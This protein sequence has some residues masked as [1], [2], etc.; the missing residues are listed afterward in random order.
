[1]IKELKISN[2]KRNFRNMN[3]KYNEQEL[4]VFIAQG[5]LE[6]VRDGDHTSLACI[7]ADKRDKARLLVKDNGI[8]AGVEVAKKI[9]MF[10][11]PTANIEVFIND[12]EEVKHG[13]VAFIVECN[14]QALL[15]AERLA[16]NTMQRM[17]GIATVTRRYV[18]EV[19]GLD[20]KILDTRKTT[21]LFR[22]L[23][24]WAVFIGGGTNYRWGLYD[25]MMIKDNHIDAAGGVTQA[26]QRALDYQEANDKKL[27]ITVE[28]RDLKELG[29]VL[30]IG[31]ITRIML[32]NFSV[33][34]QKEAVKIING[35]F[36]VE[37][38]GGITLET[39][40]D[41]A[42]TGVDFVSIGALTH[43][44]QSLDLSLKII[45]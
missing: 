43:S 29:E 35:R 41:K 3:F 15:R 25:W 7:P 27:N 38:S 36:E 19:K 9:F 37:A 30:A 1:M 45:K 4:N 22:M 17:S 20:V 12:G 8:L 13:D 42:A 34:L 21:P 44:N 5:F 16:L 23:Q 10:A 11:D 39:L 33:E 26:I 40:Y 6:D 28:V 24:K 31:Q 18:D 2:D 14:A 32:D